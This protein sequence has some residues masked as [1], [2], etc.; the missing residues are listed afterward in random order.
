[1]TI[2]YIEVYIHY[3]TPNDVWPAMRMMIAGSVEDM[4]ARC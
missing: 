2:Y 3:A 4:A 1:M